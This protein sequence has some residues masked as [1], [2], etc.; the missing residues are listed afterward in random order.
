M[1]TESPSN[2]GTDWSLGAALGAALGASVCCILPLTLVSLGIGGAWIG[3]LT[4]MAPYRWIFVTIAAGTLSYA[5]YNE[6][7]LSRR[8]DCEC[9]TAFSSGTRRA[10][11]GFGALAVAVLIVSPYLIAPSPSA[12]TQEAHATAGGTASKEASQPA[13]STP[14]SFRQVVLEVEGMTCKTC[15]ITVRKA[16][17]NV[18]GVYSVEATYEPP[19]A[20]VRFDPAITSVEALARATKEVGYPSKRKTAS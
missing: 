7:R 18:E 2:T 3:G 13:S 19:E 20:V 11:L 12:A 15:P 16:L 9:E 17:E 5:G 6:W 1:S 8:P 10:L 4:A 14:A